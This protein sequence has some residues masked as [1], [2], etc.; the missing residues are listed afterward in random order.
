MTHQDHAHLAYIARLRP[1]I[2][3]EDYRQLRD[4]GALPAAQIAAEV[5]RLR[6]ELSAVATYLPSALVREQRSRRRRGGARNLLGGS[7]LFADLRALPAFG[8][9][10]A[11]W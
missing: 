8:T 9:L 2:S 4:T 10:S 5:A 1:Y 11:H 7:V 6:G 3:P